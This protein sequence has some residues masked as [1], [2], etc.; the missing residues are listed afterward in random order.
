MFCPNVNIAMALTTS[1]QDLLLKLSGFK[2]EHVH[3]DLIVVIAH[4]NQSGLRLT[5]DGNFSWEAFT[6]WVAPFEPNQMIFA[7]C[8]A[9]QLPQAQALFDGIP[10]L[11][12]IYA[13]PLKTTKNQVEVVKFL[14]PYLLIRKSKDTELIRIA[15]MVNYVLT[16]GV[17]F[18]WTRKEY[19]T[20]GFAKAVEWKVFQNLIAKLRGV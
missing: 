8:E 20:A 11:K 1:Q 6:Q 17:I 16:G 19:Q 15:Q 2:E 13:P 4:S 10:T 9:G 7:A 14:V 5:S 12:E 3:F 18:R